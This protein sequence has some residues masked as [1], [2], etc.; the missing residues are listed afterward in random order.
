M[1]YKRL[2]MLLRAGEEPDLALVR[3]VPIIVST[4]L[5]LA[6]YLLI[7]WGDLRLFR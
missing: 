2:V 1:H 4:A 5:W 6:S 7:S 3:D